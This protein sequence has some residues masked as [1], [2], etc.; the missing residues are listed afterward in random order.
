MAWNHRGR[1][2]ALDAAMGLSYMHTQSPAVL[3]RGAHHTF[4]AYN[5]T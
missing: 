5:S 3:H 4:F 1:Q 2:A